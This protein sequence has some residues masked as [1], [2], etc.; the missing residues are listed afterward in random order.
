MGILKNNSNLKNFCLSLTSDLHKQIKME[1]TNESMSMT[2]FIRSACLAKVRECTQ[3]RLEKR[4][5]ILQ[6]D[7]AYNE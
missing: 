3:R 4:K 5:A 1:A 6:G 2:G 7:R